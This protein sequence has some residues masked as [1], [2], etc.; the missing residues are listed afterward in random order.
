MESLSLQGQDGR[1]EKQTCS[2]VLAPRADQCHG[3]Q[4]SCIQTP[5]PSTRIAA[6]HAASSHCVTPDCDSLLLTFFM[7]AEL[8]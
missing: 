3:H 8:Y 2:C 7:A 6:A 1:L 5:P 4:D